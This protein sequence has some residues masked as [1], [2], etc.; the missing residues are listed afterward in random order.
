MEIT[1]LGTGGADWPNEP[2]EG[3]FRH[4]AS[5]LVNGKILVD[6]GPGIYE[7]ANSL[8]GVDLSGLS[9]IFLTHTHPDHYSTDTLEALIGKAKGPVTL[10]YHSGARPNLHL[11]ERSSYGGGLSK[12]SLKKLTLKPL[13]RG[14]RVTVEKTSWLN[15]EAN[16][17]CDH[18]ERG[19]HYIVS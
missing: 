19:S 6:P 13:R 18:G 15:L 8:P 4:H 12:G 14:Q 9:A 2:T 17:I 16:H 11:E 7:Y 3:F 1:L 5:I 10:Y